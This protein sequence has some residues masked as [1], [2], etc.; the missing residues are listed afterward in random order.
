MTLHHSAMAPDDL[1]DRRSVRFHMRGDEDLVACFVSWD[2]LS[3]LEN[4]PAATTAER[5]QRFET[6]RPRI[7]AA[8]MRK[9]NRGA[10]NEITLDASDVR[11]GPDV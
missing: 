3:A 4:G 8:V 5:L 1:A 6:H 11:D 9:Y 10:K 7:E 2:A